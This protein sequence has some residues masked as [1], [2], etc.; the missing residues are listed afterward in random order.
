MLACHTNGYLAT[1]KPA[2]ANALFL[3]MWISMTG[4]VLSLSS[5]FADLHMPELLGVWVSP[6]HKHEKGYGTRN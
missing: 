2:I 3:I 4:E 1:K 5:P 6:G